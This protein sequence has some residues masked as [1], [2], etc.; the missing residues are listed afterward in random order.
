MKPEYEQRERST[1]IRV[2]P[3]TQENGSKVSVMVKE[4]KCGPM[5]QETKA[6]GRVER[7][8]V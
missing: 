1:F 6:L 3:N 5:A 7:P 8:K 4:S 2:E